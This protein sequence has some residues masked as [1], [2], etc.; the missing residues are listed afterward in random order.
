M[1]SSAM[2]KSFTATDASTD[3]AMSAMSNTLRSTKPFDLPPP[4]PEI[5][6]QAGVLPARKEKLMSVE[7]RVL[8]L[9]AIVVALAIVQVMVNYNI[10]RFMRA[11]NERFRI[12]EKKLNR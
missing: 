7:L 6:A 1:A 2:T 9:T 12:L 3:S 4:H 11:T 10:I 5:P 8:I